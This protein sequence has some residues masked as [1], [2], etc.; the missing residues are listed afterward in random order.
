MTE[1]VPAPASRPADEVGG[2]LWRPGNHAGRLAL[3]DAPTGR[4][5]THGQLAAEVAAAAESLAAPR[6]LAF[7]FADRS[8]GST[9]ALLAAWAAGHAVALLEPELDAA[10]RARLLAAYRPGLVLDR[11]DAP[12]PPGFRA[13]GAVLDRGI[14]R[15]D[16]PAEPP[17]HPE[18]ALL[19]STSGSTGNPRVAR[20]SA[21]A[22]ASNA[23]AIAEALRIGPGARA[24]A[25]LPLP[26][27]YGLSVLTSH[28]AAGAAFVLTPAS[29][30]E[31][32]FWAAMAEAGVTSMAGVPATWGIVAGRLLGLAPSSLADLTVA[33]GRLPAEQVRRLHRWVADRGGRFWVMYGQTEATARIAVLPPETLPERAGCA[34]RAIPGGTLLVDAGEG[35]AAVPEVEGEI[36]YRGPNVMMGYAEGR[37]DLARGDELG[38]ELR[39]GDRG[40]LDAEGFL[41]VT[42]RAARMGKVFGM[43]FDLDEVE[44]LAAAWGPTAVTGGEDALV[45]HCAW[46]DAESHAA[47]RRELAARLRLHPSGLVFRRVEAI[48]LTRRG[49]VDYARLA[50]EAR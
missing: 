18:L 29:P 46:G 23:H 44:A 50:R 21:R 16:G 32:G 37:A 17:P 12:P 24:I 10:A 38:G 43:R 41:T 5:W 4:R 35:P 36:V 20:L 33:G 13:A 27:A 25:S 45:L 15:R 1:P 47:R 2:A 26:Y 11:A 30:V 7:V 34:G 28:L 49:K 6:D 39:T 8:P 3:V 31:R 42:G 22:V 14:A 9:V 19:L 48:P 40:R